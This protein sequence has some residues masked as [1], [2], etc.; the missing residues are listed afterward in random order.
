M[1]GREKTLFVWHEGSKNPTNII[2][3]D[4]Q[5]SSSIFV[6]LNGDIY[7]DDGMLHG[8]V[9]KW[10]AKNDTLVT[11]MKDIK[12]GCHGLF[13]DKNNTLYCG[14]MYHQMVVKR[15]LNNDN[16]IMLNTLAAGTGVKGSASDQLNFPQGIFVDVNFDLYVADSHNHR[17]QLFQAGQPSGV[18]VAGRQSAVPTIILES[19]FAVALDVEKYLF[20]M[21]SDSRILGSGVNGFRCIVGCYGKGS[22]PD[23]LNT[24]TGFSFDRSGN[25]FVADQWNDRIQKFQY[26]G[27]SCGKLK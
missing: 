10:I 5:G 12:L 26:L 22:E 2:Y 9:L 14:M 17:I 4:F 25:I 3:G 19:P 13:V 7:I 8:Q 24:A 27:K 15:S 6:T 16:K 20:I 11:V 21:D 18:T 1:N 23:R